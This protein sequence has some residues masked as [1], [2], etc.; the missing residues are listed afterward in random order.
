MLFA[1]VDIETTGSFASANGITEIAI[2]IHDGEKVIHFYESLVN[3]LVPIPF[4][5]Q[6]LTGIDNEMVASA[7][8]F[9]EIAG[10][11]HE[12]LQDKVFVAHNVNFD[13][14][15]VKHHL[16]AAGFDLDTRKLCT[17]RLA[18]KVLPGMGSY[19]LGKLTHQ[20]GIRHKDAHRA[21][22]DARATAELL[23][24][25][26]EKD[27]TGVLQS[28]LKGRNRE[29]YLPPH[30]PVSEVDSL[31]ASP[32]VYYFQ[33]AAG[34]T[35]YVG[36]AKN[37]HRRVKSHFSN[38][39]ASRQKQ[40]FIRE[41]VRITYRQC[42]TEL[43][44]EILES[45]EIR[46]IWPIHNRSQKGYLAQFALITYDDMQGYTR[47]TI[48]KCRPGYQ[49]LYTFN[50]IAEGERRLKELAEEFALC[51]RLCNLAVYTEDP[52]GCDCE[53]HLPPGVYNKI[54]AEAVKTLKK[55]LPTFALV[56][57][58]LDENEHSCILVKEGNFC[59]M[60]YLDFD[61][62]ELK[63]LETLQQTMEPLQDNDHIRNLIFRHATEYPEKCVM[64]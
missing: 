19:G 48:E 3:P 62:A 36:K 8:K 31:P 4:F 55:R 40:D 22:S 28:M 29:S 38:N 12:L 53:D 30:L 57:K 44:A 11:V 25:I 33:N 15:F 49:P 63:N 18:R 51:P 46:R 35:I 61:K 5:I 54:V 37:L 23:S 45:A 47:F 43:M 7:P 60:G 20:L 56:D 50:T 26:I 13:Y 39:R 64:L 59:G 9:T 2:V 27:T 17:I 34:K 1:I 10:Q 14:S 21:G 58:G 42:A 6:R 41:T 32:G 24:I 52:R 16:K